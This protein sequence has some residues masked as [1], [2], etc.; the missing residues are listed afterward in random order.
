MSV[1]KLKLSKSL[2]KSNYVKN[3]CIKATCEIKEIAD[4]HDHKL[5]PQLINDLMNF[6]EKEISTGKFSQ[7]DIDKSSLLK[8]IIE[9]TFGSELTEE[10]IKFIDTQ[11]QYII[12][13]KLIKKNIIYIYFKTCRF[14]RICK[15]SYKLCKHALFNLIQ[16]KIQS[17]IPI[18]NLLQIHGCTTINQI[19]VYNIG[20]Q[21]ANIAGTYGPATIKVLSIILLFL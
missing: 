6:L 14:N 3:L 11:V 21:I 9:S 1:S 12:D 8:H 5:N 18:I 2:S 4:Y 15:I 7:S 10:E 19:V 20:A 16:S 13:N 17:Q